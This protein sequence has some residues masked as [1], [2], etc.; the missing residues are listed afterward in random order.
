[1]WLNLFRFLDTR[2]LNNNKNLKNRHR[3]RHLAPD[4]RPPLKK[5][6]ADMPHNTRQIK[7]VYPG[8]WM[9]IRTLGEYWLSL[10]DG[11]ADPWRK[12]TKIRINLWYLTSSII[13]T[14]D[15]WLERVTLNNGWFL[16]C[17]HSNNISCNISNCWNECVYLE[18]NTSFIVRVG[19]HDY[20]YYKLMRI[21]LP[22]L[23]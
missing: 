2:I 16:L 20:D 14:V 6:P 18:I 22:Y 21:V 11:A 10:S 19:L 8:S 13:D 1:M 23:Q 9:T 7:T 4:R 12:Q 17:L 15:A 3:L 5:K